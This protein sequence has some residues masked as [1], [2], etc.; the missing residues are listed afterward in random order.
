DGGRGASWPIR[1]GGAAAERGGSAVPGGG[2]R[3]EHRR[4]LVAAGAGGRGAAGRVEEPTAER[5][6]GGGV[7]GDQGG[8][9]LLRELG[10]LGGGAAAGVVPLGQVDVGRGAGAAVDVE[11]A[12]GQNRRPHPR[13]RAA[14]G[15]RVDQG[16]TGLAVQYGAVAG[17]RVD[18]DDPQVGVGPLVRGE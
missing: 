17:V 2:D 11:P 5:V 9:G 1:R 7:R 18:R 10:Q 15:H 14:G 13:P 8:A 3:G 12:A 4:G 16:D 6:Q